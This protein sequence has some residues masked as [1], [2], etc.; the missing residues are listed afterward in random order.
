MKYDYVL[1]PNHIHTIYTVD[2]PFSLSD[3][4]PDFHK[5]TS[6]QI[7]SSPFFRQKLEYI[8]FN[9]FPKNGVYV[10]TQRNIY[11]QVQ[12]IICWMSMVFYRLKKFGNRSR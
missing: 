8:L 6:Q 10:S 1:M 9:P 5:Y 11:I 3:I 7:E 12:G 2:H 4:L